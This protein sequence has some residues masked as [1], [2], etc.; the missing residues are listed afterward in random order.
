MKVWSWLWI[1]FAVSKPYVFSLCLKIFDLEFSPGSVLTLESCFL[2]IYSDL[3]SLVLTRWLCFHSFNSVICVWF[4]L[5]C[6][7]LIYTDV[8]VWLWTL[9]I[10]PAGRLVNLWIRGCLIL[11]YFQF[12]FGFRLW[13]LHFCPDL[14]EL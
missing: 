2:L 10:L 14:I 4:F 9:Q 13:P 6:L 12:G 3:I 1:L 7:E 5:D 11:A 8:S